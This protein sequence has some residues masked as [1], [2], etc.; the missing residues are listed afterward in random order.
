MTVP[1]KRFCTSVLFL[2]GFCA[3]SHLRA[4]SAILSQ[5]VYG[6]VQLEYT[7]DGDQLDFHSQL[8]T[9]ARMAEELGHRKQNIVPVRIE[10]LRYVSVPFIGLNRSGFPGLVSDSSGFP[11][12]TG[13]S[14]TGLVLILGG[15][16]FDF[17]VCLQLIAFG[18]DHLSDIEEKQRLREV[19][20][21]VL[22]VNDKRKTKRVLSLSPDQIGEAL[23]YS[24]GLTEE[25]LTERHWV[26]Y[27]PYWKERAGNYYYS[28]GS[29]RFV[30][31][32]EAAKR[33]DEQSG[34]YRM[35][36]SMAREVL[37]LKTV[38]Q[39]LCYEANRAVVFENDSV[40]Y[41]I[42]YRKQRAYGPMRIDSVPS[43]PLPVREIM[44]VSGNP[45][46]YRMVLAS[47]HEPLSIAFFPRDIVVVRR[48]DE[49]QKRFLDEL[50]EERN[51][52]PYQWINNQVGGLGLV[53]VL[54]IA[55]FIYRRNQ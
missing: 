54:L 24:D 11:R 17:E 15:R 50:L 5:Y 42:D 21:D 33:P 8:Q 44:Q 16:D 19:P 45:E 34:G 31:Y 49:E 14:D 2:L 1:I 47:T 39:V 29:Y 12:L 26:A 53:V 7:S 23:K 28:S 22:F 32:P 37:A 20:V 35:E 3:S 13:R 41:F 27:S 18:L 51:T 55:Y 38:R 40:F 46:C 4:T 43:Y 6:N 25:M 10:L 9:L 36:L 30:V 52:T 48:F